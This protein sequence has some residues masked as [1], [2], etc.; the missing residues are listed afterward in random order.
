ML[1]WGLVKNKNKT[2]GAIL[3]NPSEKAPLFVESSIYRRVGSTNIQLTKTEFLTTRD[4][5]LEPEALE[6]SEQKI[7]EFMSV[8]DEDAFTEVLLIP[9]L[10]HL[11][12]RSVLGKGHRDKT[13]E[14]GQD[15]RSFKL[16][17]PT[18]HWIY[19]AA[20]VKTG[21]IRYSSSEKSSNIENILTQ[22][23]MIFDYEMFDAETNT[24]NL[25]DHVLLVTSGEIN[26][27]ARLLL[28]QTL[29]REKRRKILM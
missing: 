29:A 14:F 9:F 6:L 28:T 4:K 24:M 13:L 5:R 18:G 3:V 8:A 11:G 20:Q 27:G 23:R 12:F 17:L 16:Q 26:E 10:R 1:S 21:N 19:C 15:I 25:P 22:L 2:L 7:R